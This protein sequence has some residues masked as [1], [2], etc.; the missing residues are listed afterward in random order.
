MIADNDSDDASNATGQVPE[1]TLAGTG[2][3]GG[4]GFPA[5]DAE[6]PRGCPICRTPVCQLPPDG[7]GK[8]RSHVVV[9]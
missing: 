5:Q 2:F 7:T 4:H 8:P 1:N 6:K 3:V 9:V